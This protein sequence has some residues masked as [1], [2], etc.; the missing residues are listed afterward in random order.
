MNGPAAVA[1]TLAVLGG[2]A[3]AAAVARLR[4]RGDGW[5]P[6]RS[7]AAAAGLVLLAAALLPPLAEVTSFP[8]HVA[9]HLLAAMAAPVALALGAPVTLALRTLPGPGRRALLSAVRSRPVRWVTTAP[10]VLLLAAGGAWAYYLTP[11]FAAAHHRPWLG[12]L[13]H[14]HMFLAGCLL[15]WYLAGP[16]PLPRPRTGTALAVL[17]LAAGSH[18]VL[19]KLMYAHALP[20]HGGPAAEIRRGAQVMFYGGDVVT[21]ALA[22]AVLSAW[23]ARTG[24]ELRR[25]ARR[26]VAPSGE[27]AGIALRCDGPATTRPRR[28]T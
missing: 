7:A 3:Y 23:Y 5:P 8:G 18:D 16:D 12:A 15:A 11:L 27:L 22:V 4:R 14:V 13:V 6:A 26:E 25:A 24:R 1:L 2:G 9:R 20:H 17:V 10:A 28:T 21:V 19:A